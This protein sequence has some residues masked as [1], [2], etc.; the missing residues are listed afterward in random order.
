MFEFIRFS[1]DDLIEFE[2]EFFVALNVP[3]VKRVLGLGTN[4]TRNE[5][6]NRWL[7]DRIE[8]WATMQN[9]KSFKLMGPSLAKH[10]GFTFNRGTY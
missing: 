10:S 2:I 4:I 7:Y 5:N 8:N 9:P 3:I 1:T 6:P